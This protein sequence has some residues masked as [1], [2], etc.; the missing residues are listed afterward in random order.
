MSR[1]SVMSYKTF[2]VI[3]DSEFFRPKILVDSTGSETDPIE[4][5]NALY[6]KGK[7]MK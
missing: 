7:R 5:I 3:R 2:H 1:A 6:M 4:Q